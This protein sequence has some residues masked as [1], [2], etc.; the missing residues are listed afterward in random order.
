VGRERE[1]ARLWERWVGA[2]A[3]EQQAVVISGEAGI[4]KSRLVQE[5]RQ[6]LVTTPHTWI[7]CGAT[8]FLQNTPFHTVTEMLRQA[9]V[10]DSNEEPAQPGISDLERTMTAAGLEARESVPLFAKLLSIPVPDQYSQSFL[11]PEQ[12]RRRQ[13]VLL[14]A[15]ITALARQQPLVVVI[16]D[17][18]WVDPSTLELLTMLNAAVAPAPMLLLY[19]ARPEFRSPWTIDR[20]HIQLNLTGLSREQAREMIESAANDFRMPDELVRTVVERTGGVPLFVEEMT[21]AVAEAGGV[22]LADRIPSTLRDSLMA[23]LDRLGQAREIAQVGAVIG[24]DFSYDLI[25]AVAPV[26]GVEL[27]MMLA[28]LVEA[29]MLYVRGTPPAASYLFKHALV[30]DT[31][32]EALLRSRRREY[33]RKIAA[34]ITERMPEAA[35]AQP[36]ILAHHFSEA[37]D[38]EPALAA[39]RRAAESASRRGALIEGEGHYARAL[40]ALRAMPESAERDQLELV[41]QLGIGQVAIATHGYM[42]QETAAAYDRARALGQRSG[43]PR[44]TV[45]V[46]SGLFAIPL[47]RGEMRATQA[48]CEQLLAAARRDGSAVRMV[49]AH[50]LDGVASYHRGD[51]AHARECFANASALYAEADFRGD[52][53]D[54]GSEVLEYAALAS[55]QLGLADTAR[56]RISAALALAER[57]HKPYATAHSQF[58]AGFLHALLR[59]SDATR[60]HAEAAVAL[61]HERRFPHFVNAGRILL[62][63]ALGDHGDASAVITD[64]RDALN[65]YMGSGNRLAAG[66]FLGFLAETLAR[67]GNYDEALRTID[68]AIDGSAEQLVD[69]AHLRWL[70]GAVLLQRA[71]GES[72]STN[73]GDLDAAERSFQQTIALAG[74]IGAKFYA[75]RAATSLA[76]IRR[77]RGGGEAASLLEPFFE[78]LAEGF[79]T[80]DA[81]EAKSLLA[82]L[83]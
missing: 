71:G 5:F 4:G 74:R 2:R 79:D 82:E 51:L 78:N 14:T 13:L 6:R 53:Q 27:D 24:H 37:G 10:V 81:I 60:R 73:S 8:Q 75:L 32:Y 69:Q 19:T 7:E 55:W 50:Y 9:L 33:H 66:I 41:L 28:R 42:A 1:L 43:S 58:Y 67:A 18:H 36:E 49:W 16:E 77:A 48:I 34:A 80:A 30:R 44:R 35:R 57:L 21:R 23:R 26:A 68:E 56:E 61:S 39:W 83:N 38:Q 46:L 63:W 22:D 45:Q 12:E 54:P 52:T 15:W 25:S 62:G 29:E 70:H 59:D 20:R 65:A 11:S 47:L 72:S 64:M 17:L 31:A 76:R 3:G 40:A